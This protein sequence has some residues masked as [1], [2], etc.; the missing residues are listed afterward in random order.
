VSKL[1]IAWD[2]V[3][4]EYLRSEPVSPGVVVSL[5]IAHQPIDSSRLT[6]HLHLTVHPNAIAPKMAEQIQSVTL[7]FNY[8][9]TVSDP[10]IL[11]LLHLLQTEIQAPQPM[12]QLFASSIVTVLTT[13]LLQNSRLEYCR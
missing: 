8:S 3:T 13:Y 12:C 1:S 7:P 10:S 2:G 4:V 5:S 6:G 9:Q 11:H